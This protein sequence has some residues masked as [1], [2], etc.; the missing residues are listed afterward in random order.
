MLEDVVMVKTRITKYI[1]Y[2]LDKIMLA[3]AVHLRFQYFL[4]YFD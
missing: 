4:I 3:N 1:G 2:K